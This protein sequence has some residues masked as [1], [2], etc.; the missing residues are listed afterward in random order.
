MKLLV[1]AH[2]PPPHHGQSYMV[3]LMLDGFGGDARRKT[4][5]AAPAS[6]P[7]VECYHV[8]C[9]YSEGL[10]DIGAFRLGKFW[11][12]LR[13]CLEAIWCRFRYGVRAFYYVPAPGKRA[14]L[15]RDWIVML[16]CRPFFRDFIHHWHAVGLGDWLRRE[17]NWFERWLTHRL[18]G[19]PT[20]GIA[21][22][23]PNLRDALWF[24]SRRVAIVANGIPDPCPDFESA[25]LPRRRARLEARLHLLVGAPGESPDRVAAG[26]EPEIFHVLYL[27]HC[28]RDKG[29]FD[30]IDGVALANTRLRTEGSPLRLHLTIAGAFLSGEE[31]REFRERLA[32][33][34][35]NAP[36]PCV[37]YAGFV[38]GPEKA[39]LLRLA[40]AFCFPTY[41]ANEGQPVNL[42]EAMAHGL[43]IVTTRWRAI[44]DSLPAEGARFVAPQAPA[45]IAEMLCSLGGLDAA[46]ALREEFL[47]RF[48]EQRFLEG[49]RAA[50]LDTSGRTAILPPPAPMAAAD[51][52]AGRREVLQVFSRYEFVGGEETSVRRIAIALGSMHRVHSFLYSTREF[53]EFSLFRL[54]RVVFRNPDVEE[55]LGALLRQTRF[56]VWQIH[57]VFPAMSPV[58]YRLAFEQR[59]PIIQYL[60]N[61]RFSCAN[62]FLLNRGDP[63]ERCAQ[64]NFWPA[65]NRGCWHQSHL[66]SGLMGLV[67]HH[68]REMGVFE[69]VNRWVALSEDHRAQHLGIGVPPD[70]LRVIPH[71]FEPRT[72]VLPPPADGHALFVGRLSPEKGVLHLLQAWSLLARPDRRLVIIGEGP[73]S[74]VL[75]AYAAR[76]RLTNVTFTGFL[77]SE[78]QRPWVA[79]ALFSLVPSIWREPFG[80]VVLE[81]WAN[82]RA[83]IA[84]AIGG[85]SEMIED[86]RTGLLADPRDPASLATAMQRLFEDPG[87][88]AALGV[89]GRERLATHYNRDLW[90]QRTRELYE[91]L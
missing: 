18:L 90:L 61:F 85:L 38:G 81:A 65:F 12:A 30:T 20:L 73:E 87:L 29:L 24:R 52:Q 33:P 71:F 13:F 4:A 75:Q 27:A 11:S 16:L 64:G 80:M 83:V 3:K 26:K 45:E 7:G 36:T 40:D 31:E 35:V 57:N 2:V 51:R 17:G 5:A 68:V 48:T 88:A 53:R 42:I 63:C 19:H 91:S 43:P 79:G 89:A 66:V 41:Y 56:D 25:I 39:A 60:H 67:L 55:A 49:L 84:H 1:F 44:P 10:E 32:Q 47:R 21:L 77:S 72:P 54:P 50:L 62:G 59:V 9:R 78:A 8:N 46:E 15:Y 69:R 86:G 6:V 76:H 58:V 74:P 14:A 22:A 82:R 23:I 34:D 70:R 37:T 28:T